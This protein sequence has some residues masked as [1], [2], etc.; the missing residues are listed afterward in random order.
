MKIKKMLSK[1][2]AKRKR[3]VFFSI[4]LMI[5]ML[6]LVL[7]FDDQGYFTGIE[8]TGVY[9]Y[10]Y[11]IE[12]LFVI[13][14]LRT[15]IDSTYDIVFTRERFKVVKA[16][17]QG[18]AIAYNK[19]LYVDVIEENQNDFEILILLDKVKRSKAMFV[20]NNEYALKHDKYLRSYK[21]A[22]DY[23]DSNSFYAYT[24]K[25]GGAKKYFYLYK[26]Y[27]TCYNAQ[28]SDKSISYIKKVIEEYSLS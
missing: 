22:S 28:F 5:V 8:R 15:F 11:I 24:I 4:V 19:V 13:N 16:F 20:L 12:A 21:T 9:I 17:T 26:L 7:I 3:T 10:L 27:K 18:V 2:S 25:N 14:I 1:E 6:Y 23:Y